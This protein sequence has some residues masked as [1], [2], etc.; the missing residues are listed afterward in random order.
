M[1]DS[2]VDPKFNHSFPLVTGVGLGG[3]TRINGGQYTCGVPAEYNAWSQEG[4]PGWGYADLKPYF[5]KSQT[6]VGPVPSDWHGSSGEY[7]I[8]QPSDDLRL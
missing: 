4:R 1:F 5:N 6:W 3:T 2:S 8:F 7:I